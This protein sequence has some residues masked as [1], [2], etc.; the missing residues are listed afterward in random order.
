MKIYIIVAILPFLIFGCKKDQVIEE[1]TPLKSV[2]FGFE[3]SIEDWVSLGGS[4]ERNVD[5]DILISS[6]TMSEGNYSC[7][8]TVSTSS[9][10]SGGNRAELTFDQNATQGDNTWYEYSFYIPTNYQDV[11]LNDNTGLVNWQILG[12]WHQQPVVSDGETWDSYTGENASPPIAIYYNYFDTTDTNF[13]NI[14]QD[15]LSNS[16]YGFNHNWNEVSTISIVYGNSPIAIVEI[17]KGEWVR[18]KFN[19]KWSENNEGFIQAWIDGN[20]FTNGKVF[21]ANMLNKASHYFK[22]GLYR[23]PTIPYTNNLYYD[24]INIWND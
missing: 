13:Q 1:K 15:P 3:T 19:I 21:G 17:N 2:T 18:L 24:D 14:L 23:N 11:L 22:F 16:V 5:D 20:E 6:D 8:F 7:K 4:G 9:I 12:Q 10:V